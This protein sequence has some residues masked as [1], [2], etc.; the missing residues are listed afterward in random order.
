MRKPTGLVPRRSTSSRPVD[1]SAVGSV[2]PRHLARRILP[3]TTMSKWID[4]DVE[5]QICDAQRYTMK[6]TGIGFAK[7]PTWVSG[8]FIAAVLLDRMADQLPPFSAVCTSRLSL[9]Q[10]LTSVARINAGVPL[11]KT[12]EKRIQRPDTQG[13]SD[14]ELYSAPPERIDTVTY[15]R[16]REAL[17]GWQGRLR[18]Q[19]GIFMAWQ[20]R[21]D[22]ALRWNTEADETIRVLQ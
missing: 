15:L 2:H 20:W 14:F 12:K 16:L 6:M 21:G 3:S 4:Q 18:L 1:A 5:V 9:S 11:G 17:D 22:D 10:A 13:N 7:H 8:S 19:M